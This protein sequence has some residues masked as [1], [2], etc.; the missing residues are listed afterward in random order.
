[1]KVP[2]VRFHCA[3]Y[4]QKEPQTKQQPNN[5]KT[6]TQIKKVSFEMQRREAP[7]SFITSENTI[8]LLYNGVC[9]CV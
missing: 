4:A 2:L 9:V 1:M 5:N 3:T 6:Q 7:K 8:D